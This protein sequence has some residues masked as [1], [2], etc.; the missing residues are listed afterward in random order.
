MPSGK[1]GSQYSGQ[2]DRAIR[3]FRAELLRSVPGENPGR[4]RRA[5]VLIVGSEPSQRV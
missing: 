5:Y 1:G 3:Q 2:L 4:G